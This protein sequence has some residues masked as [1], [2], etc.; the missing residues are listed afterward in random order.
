MVLMGRVVQR[1]GVTEKSYFQ[2]LFP[3]EEVWGD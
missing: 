2:C 1:L 3:N